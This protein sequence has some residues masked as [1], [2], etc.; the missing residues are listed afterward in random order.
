MEPPSWFASIIERRSA[1]S[2]KEGSLLLA[3]TSKARKKKTLPMELL[4]QT[5]RAVVVVLLLTAGL[6]AARADTYVVTN[7]NTSGPGSLSQAISDSN[8]RTG[9]DTIV[10]NVPGSGVQ[11]IDFSQGFLPEIT[12]SLVIDGYTQPGSHPNTFSVGNDAVILIHIDGANRTGTRGLVL[13][14]ANAANC[15]IRGLAITGFL[16][17]PNPNFPYIPLNGYGIK[18]STDAGAGNVIQ[19]NFI[20]L[21]PDGI[22]PSKNYE[23]VRI[24]GGQPTIGG[25][26]P[27][28]RN[29]ISGNDTGL[30][31]GPATVIGNYVGTDATGTRA[32]GNRTGVKVAG[33]DTV[34]GGT[35]PGAGNVISGNQFEGIELGYFLAFRVTL[36]SERTVVQGNL[37]GTTADGTG[38]LGNGAMA[39]FLT[40][41]TDATIGGLD[42]AAGNV[43]AYNGG[44]VY[45]PGGGSFG[46]RNSIL[47]NSIYANSNRGIVLLTGANNSQSAPVITSSRIS[48]G[49]ATI[50]GTL[51]SLANT[52]FVVQFFADSQSLTSSEQTYLGSKN[53]TT[54]GNGH[55]SFVATFPV[56][57]P[58][59]D[60]NATATDPSGNTSEFSRN[61]A[62]LQNI[63]TRAF[64]GR[65]DDA[66]IAGFIAGSG[67]V[68][69]RGIGPSLKAAGF[70][71]F[72]ADPVLELHDKTGAQIRFNDNWQDD[73]AQASEIQRAGLAPANPAE[74][75]IAFFPAG[76]SASYTA[77]LRGKNDTTGVGLVEA[78]GP[79]V[80][81]SN[82]SSRGLVGT[83]G[84]VLIGGF[85]VADGNES[86][87][88][89]VR[90]I[91][92]SSQAFGVAGPLADPVVELHDGNGLLIQSNDGWSDTQGDDLQTVGLAPA[93]ARES[94]ILMRLAA[95]SYTAIVR[96]KNDSTGVALVEIYDL[97]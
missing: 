6:S 39:I 65:G 13:S 68:V 61:V 71:N 53:V 2:T 64:V 15:L 76:R 88:I 57:D 78:Y 97:R 12:D 31:S 55:A 21:N 8:A 96:G 26:D 14:G 10:F 32:V 66:L 74:S 87:R 52:T 70:D 27:A 50:N 81:L 54:N 47:S 48:N 46:Q 35:A 75:A 16:S 20:G 95:G 90:A 67:E 4:C 69:L 44:G 72:L 24:E 73:Q 62:Y 59:V 18:I 92:P 3:V 7:T 30:I 58:D 83:G 36:A 11:R 63:S 37:I 29:V 9:Q 80:P 40:R 34:I 22:T 23:G 5:I 51:D 45:L 28:A 94:A 1:R 85:I 93:D 82:L 56:A 17:A 49:I 38:A 84:N 43:I 41:S 79:G 86:P 25:V 91:G 89:V 42:P 33:Q 60:F 77:V 19:G